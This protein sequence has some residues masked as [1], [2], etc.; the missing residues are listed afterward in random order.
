MRL[1]TLGL[2]LLT[3]LP[4]GASAQ[5]PPDTCVVGSSYRTPKINT[6]NYILG[7]F[8][9]TAFDE[10]TTKSFSYPETNLVV[11]VGVDYDEADNP[12]RKGM[13]DWIA[14]AIDVSD[15]ERDAFNS[16]NTAVA[17][18]GYGK[19]WKGLYLQKVVA[20]GETMY[21]FTIHCSRERKR[22]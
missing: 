6:S 11:N 12:K 5:P 7:I 20:E 18:A 21:R 3:L 10:K 8:R 17:R 14:V 19:K 2:L 16:T 22:K 1:S 15:R 4:A 13:P 9:P